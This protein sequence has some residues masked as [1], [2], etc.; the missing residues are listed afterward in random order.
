VAGA[1]VAA[2]ALGV[3]SS[4]PGDKP[5]LVARAAAA[6]AVRDDTI[7]HFDMIGRQTN[8]DGSV[9][10]WR[11][12]SWQERAAP[13]ARRTIEVG[14]KGA[15]AETASVGHTTQLYDART[16]TIY[17]GEDPTASPQPQPKLSP[18]PR[19]GTSVVTVTKLSVGSDGKPQAHTTHIVLSTDEA[20]RL[21]QRSGAAEPE[22]AEPVEE[23]FRQQILRLL[24]SGAVVDG[25][26]RVGGRDAVR[27]VSQDGRTSYLVESGTYA[28][29]ELRTRGDGGGV[30][31]SFKAYEELP[32]TTANRALLSLTSQHPAAHVNRDPDDYR[33]AQS[34]LFPHG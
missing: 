10:S 28:P 17:V 19:P 15:P 27:I 30:T 6:L 21:V 23:P 34:H 16:K 7:L 29:I 11:S 13:F 31:L 3:L 1:A 24:H 4:L 9:V 18:G 8:P 5:S 26:V 20:K 25:H 32:R 2:I 14:P 33:A 22:P 12:E